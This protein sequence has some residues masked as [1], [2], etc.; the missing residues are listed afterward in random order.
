[1]PWQK[2]NL[3]DNFVTT[4]SQHS[5]ELNKLNWRSKAKL[6]EQSKTGGRHHICILE[7]TAVVVTRLWVT[8]EEMLNKQLSNFMQF[9]REE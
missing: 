1:L 8:C 6:E 7:N 4:F 5:L 9:H 2:T 3:K